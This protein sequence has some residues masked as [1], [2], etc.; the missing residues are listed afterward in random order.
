MTSAVAGPADIVVPVGCQPL[1]LR[2][3]DV[4]F[5]HTGRFAK[6]GLSEKY[7]ENDIDNGCH[8]TLTCHR[9][10]N[11][12]CVKDVK[13]CVAA[14]HRAGM[15]PLLKL[16]LLVLGCAATARAVNLGAHFVD[17]DIGDLH[18]TNATN[19]AVWVDIAWRR[20]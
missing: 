12:H 6:I 14:G 10:H 4:S 19:P 7:P 18:L 11:G 17:I 13:Y 5:L 1:P 8:S 3:A 9:V 20:K 2:R 15:P 16:G